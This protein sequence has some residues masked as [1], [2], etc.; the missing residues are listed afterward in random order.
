MK[1]AIIGGVGAVGGFLTYLF[2]GWD[3]SVVTLLIFMSIDYIT[4]LIVA[5]IFHK[6]GKSETGSLNSKACWKGLAKKGVTLLL[7]I[8]AHFLDVT[9]GVNF[10]RD[11]V[12]IAFISNE[13]ISI[14]ENAGLMGIPIPAVV[15]KAIDMLNSKAELEEKK[16]V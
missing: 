16:E 7:I 3:S 13:V 4:G 12:A 1:S 10:I 5:G 2:G 8:V 14:I 15:T 6:S 9:L 11:G